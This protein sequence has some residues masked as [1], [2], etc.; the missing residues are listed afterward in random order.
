MGFLRIVND[1]R[2][3]QRHFD[4]FESERLEVVRG[5]VGRGEVVPDEIVADEEAVHA[6][7]VAANK[8]IA[9][10]RPEFLQRLEARAVPAS[11]R[12]GADGAEGLRVIGYDPGHRGWD[13]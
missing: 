1:P 5:R 3:T 4:A 12:V 11:E 6:A 9:L 2:V 13:A 8:A 7:N 10:P